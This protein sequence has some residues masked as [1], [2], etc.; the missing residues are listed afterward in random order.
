AKAAGT[1][2]DPGHREEDTGTL[3]RLDP[4]F[5]QQ[6]LSPDTLGQGRFLKAKAEPGEL[7]LD[8]ESFRPDQAVDL[9]CSTAS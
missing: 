1:T 4:P 3:G 9:V 8:R 7:R 5:R 2:S 6:D